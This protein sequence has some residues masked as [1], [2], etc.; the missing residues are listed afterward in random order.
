MQEDYKLTMEQFADAV[1][2]GLGRAMIHV[3]RYGLDDIA[4]ILLDAC[5]HNKTYDAQCEDQ[6]TDWLYA[7]FNNS[8]QYNGFRDAI[9]SV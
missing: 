7:M 9:L 2:K 8:P 6:R 5:V 4:D 3:R 1:S